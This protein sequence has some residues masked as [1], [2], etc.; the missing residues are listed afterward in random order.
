MDPCPLSQTLSPNPL[1]DKNNAVSGSTGFQP[2]YEQAGC[3]FSR[4]KGVMCAG[5]GAWREPAREETQA[6]LADNFRRL[7]HLGK[8]KA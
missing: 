5:P 4:L 3:L 1:R 2:V 6:I 7:C 8:E